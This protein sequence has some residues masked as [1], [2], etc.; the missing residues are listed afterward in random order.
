MRPIVTL[1]FPLPCLFRH[2][3]WFLGLRPVMAA[4]LAVTMMAVAARP[5][6][7]AV[8]V[9]DGSLISENVVQRVL[10]IEQWA[11]DNLRQLE[12]LTSLDKGNEILDGTQILMAQNY[13]MDNKASWQEVQ[14]LQEESLTLLH[15]AKSMWEEFGSAQKY[16]AAF[17]K[18]QAWDKCMQGT[19]CSFSRALEEMDDAAISQ[20]LQAYQNA[21]DMNFKLQGQIERLQ[22]LNAESENTASEAATLDALSKI[23]GHVASSMVDL[24]NQIAQLTK[25]QSHHMAK[26]SNEAL[27]HDS[28]VEAI[29]SFEDIGEPEP[30]PY[31]LPEK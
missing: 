22:Q 28:Y 3:P 1:H 10:A 12:Q 6:L 2:R 30:L 19:H 17:H 27:A 8:P 26:E 24:N 4:A 9:V 15:A 16:Y 11:H 7:G 23:N 14:A 18:A 31:K 20:S 29:T 21:E 5:A 25:L 13:A